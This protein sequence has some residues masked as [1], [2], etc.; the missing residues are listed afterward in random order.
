LRTQFAHNPNRILRLCEKNHRFVSGAAAQCQRLAES[1]AAKSTVGSLC[2]LCPY[3]HSL[4]SHPTCPS[5]T[6]L[7]ASLRA[8]R[9]SQLPPPASFPASTSC[10]P[11]CLKP[12]LPCYLKSPPH[13]ESA[14]APASAPAPTHLSLWFSCIKLLLRWSASASLQVIISERA[15]VVSCCRVM[16]SM[17]IC[18][19]H[20]S[21]ICSVYAQAC[22]RMGMCVSVTMLHAYVC[23]CVCVCVCVCVCQIQTRAC[24]AM[25]MLAVPM[26]SNA[27]CAQPSRADH[28]TH[29]N[30]W[31]E[32]VHQ[33]DFTQ[34]CTGLRG[35]QHNASN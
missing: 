1:A 32:S 15:S 6:I 19:I 7:C 3:P 25:N 20:R 29:I 5:S 16:R 28:S 8:C 4:N 9:E 11:C 12:L 21:S 34:V 14:L 10:W 31:L 18:F 33:L 30:L 26:R 2:E 27:T 13:P 35:R 17:A 23:A 22:K 24:S